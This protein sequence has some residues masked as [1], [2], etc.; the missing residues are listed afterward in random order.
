M[1]LRCPVG[2]TNPA[3]CPLLRGNPEGAAFCDECGEPLNGTASNVVAPS[4][5]SVADAQLDAELVSTPSS[6]SSSADG[7]AESIVS[8]SP[9]LQQARLV[10]EADNQEFDLSGKDSITIG[11]EDAVSGIYPDVD[12]AAHGGEEGGVS[13]L[14]AHLFVENGQYMLEDENSTN[15][16]FVDRQRLQPKMPVPLHDNEEIKLGRVLLRF[17]IS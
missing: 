15:F 1:E 6:I 11:R 5:T 8:P 10:V 9:V 12:L 4:G 17:R 2:R 3:E 13:R 14:H 7:V 16:T